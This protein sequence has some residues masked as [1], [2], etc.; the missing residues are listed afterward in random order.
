MLRG[1][2]EELH[3][4]AD[5]MRIE[6]EDAHGQRVGI[7]R[8]AG[9]PSGFAGEEA[10]RQRHQNAGAVA[11]LGVGVERAAMFQV[12]QRVE[13]QPQDFAAG[14]AMPIGYKADAAVATIKLRL[15]R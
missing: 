6:E 4:A 12:D 3:A 7:D 11:G 2:F 13:A 15:I 1:G 14:A 5:V 10:R 8:V 9:D